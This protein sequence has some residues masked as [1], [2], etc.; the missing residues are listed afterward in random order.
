MW[1][2]LSVVRRNLR[3]MRK[4]SRVADEGMSGGARN[5]AIFAQELDGLAPRRGWSGLSIIYGVVQA[6][7]AIL[8]CLSHPHVNGADGVWA[9]GHEFVQISEMNHLMVNDSMRYAILM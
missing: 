5:G 6:P 3:N 7:F 4:S 2:M 9:S 8:S 1:H